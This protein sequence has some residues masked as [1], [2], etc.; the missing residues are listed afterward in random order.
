MLGWLVGLGLLIG[1]P[2][3]PAIAPRGDADLTYIVAPLRSELSRA[4]VVGRRRAG[5]LCA[6]NGRLRWADLA[7]DPDRAAVLIADVLREAGVAADLPRD[8]RIGG[9][10]PPGERRVLGDVVALDAS[11][12][13]KETS[14]PRLFRMKIAPTKGRA[15][16]TVR[17]RV[18]EVGEREPVATY[19]SCPDF[20]IDGAESG[21]LDRG[22]AAAALD[23]AASL[24]G[25]KSETA[26]PGSST[27]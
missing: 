11:L 25:A 5:L 24:N 12:C 14:V 1:T 4:A 2:A 18:H 7:P 27:S 22:I 21:A 3:S 8:D 17:W 20:Q 26:C 9:T 16:L 23:L 10:A 15:T 13:V 6:P 19:W